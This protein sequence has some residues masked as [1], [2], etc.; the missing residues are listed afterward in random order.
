MSPPKGRDVGQEVGLDCQAGLFPL[1]DR[2]AEMGSIPV[3]DNGGEQVESSHAGVLAIAG[4]V[5]PGRALARALDAPSRRV[6]SLR[7]PFTPA[8]VALSV[9]GTFS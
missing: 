2:F 1:P 6:S 7:Y 3:N 5:E 8:G 9:K 4:A